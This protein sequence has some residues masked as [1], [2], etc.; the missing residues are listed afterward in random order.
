[1]NMATVSGEVT[2]TGNETRT[3]YISASILSNIAGSGCGLSGTGMADFDPKTITLSPNTSGPYSFDTG[4]D[5]IVNGF[6][7]TMPGTYYLA[8]KVWDGNPAEN[9][10][11]DGCFV[12]YEV[13]TIIDATI[14]CN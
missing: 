7:P 12:S 3:F 9:K 5:L 14:T 8:V 13:V 6:V 11:M 10:C 1:M 4:S 2:N